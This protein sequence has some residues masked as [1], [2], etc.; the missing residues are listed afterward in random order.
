MTLSQSGVSG[1]RV[2][3][4]EPVGYNQYG[5]E[6]IYATLEAAKASYPE[7]GWR[8]Q[9]DGSWISLD[10]DA[11]GEQGYHIYEGVVQGQAQAPRDRL[12]EAFRRLEPNERQLLT[13]ALAGNHAA[14]LSYLRPDVIAAL[15]RAD[16]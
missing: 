14:G 8:E 16:Q 3:V 5:I 4:V 9:R 2:W 15:A 7:P 13:A 1:M 11:I 6:G 10:A 12:T